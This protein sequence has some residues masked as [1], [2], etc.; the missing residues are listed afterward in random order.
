MF[1]GAPGE[2]GSRISPERLLNPR[3]GRK[4]SGAAELPELSGTITKLPPGGTGTPHDVPAQPGSAFL[5]ANRRCELSATSAPC[6][7]LPSEQPDWAGWDGAFPTATGLQKL[8]RREEKQLAEGHSAN[9]GWEEEPRLCP[10]PGEFHALM[11][12]SWQWK[13]SWKS[14]KILI[15]TIC[16]FFPQ[17][18]IASARAHRPRCGAHRRQR[19]RRCAG[20]SSAKAFC[21]SALFAGVYVGLGASL[22]F[23]QTRKTKPQEVRGL[24]FRSLS[25]R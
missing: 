5:L 22:T 20:I 9:Q 18:L 8:G 23:Q 6:G 24:W 17:K 1:L 4:Q 21:L 16:A 2:K 13:Q 11:A 3:G 7:K 19:N 12:R 15:L 25:C 14:N 10:S